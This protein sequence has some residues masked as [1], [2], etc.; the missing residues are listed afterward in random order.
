MCARGHAFAGARAAR[1]FECEQHAAA[2]R[3]SSL[4]VNAEMIVHGNEPPFPSSVYVE[5]PTNSLLIGQFPSTRA[6][7]HPGERV[8]GAVS[9]LG[10]SYATD[11]LTA[12]S[13]GLVGRV[14]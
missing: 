11:P 10:R 13:R 14:N 6:R 7:T 1:S 4:F 8:P 2:V 3:W 12:W 9:A 5:F